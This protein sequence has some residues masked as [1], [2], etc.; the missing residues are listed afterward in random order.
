MTALYFIGDEVTAAGFRLAGA[1]SRVPAAG[2][3]ADAF[4]EA[5]ERADLVLITAE[6]AAELDARELG[7]AV[8][9]AAPFVLVVPDAVSRKG[10]PDL[11]D[12]VDRVLG[13]A[14]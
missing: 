9:S 14:P 12:A 7:R 10:A 11:G 5:L 3:V 1:E 8:R 4:M 13:I 6:R 2:R